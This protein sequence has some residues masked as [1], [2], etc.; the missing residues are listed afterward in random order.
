MILQ[1]FLFLDAVPNSG[2]ELLL[3]MCTSFSFILN[4]LSASLLNFFCNVGF[5]SGGCL[6][7]G[8]EEVLVRV[9]ADKLGGE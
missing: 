6:G 5:S 8:E 1:S 4:A 9:R 7:R 3:D 2:E